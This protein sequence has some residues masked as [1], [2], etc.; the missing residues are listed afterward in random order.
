MPL[1]VR[2]SYKMSLNRILYI[3]SCCRA[4]AI[5]NKKTLIGIRSSRAMG[6]SITNSTNLITLKYTHL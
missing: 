2:I 1:G 5:L 3:T 4:L 6:I